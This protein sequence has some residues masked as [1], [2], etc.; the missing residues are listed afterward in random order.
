VSCCWPR[1]AAAVAAPAPRRRP[2]LP[3]QPGMAPSAQIPSPFPPP[4]LARLASQAARGVARRRRRP[5]AGGR[6]QPGR[7]G[8]GGRRLPC[9]DARQVRRGRQAALPVRGPLGGRQG[10]CQARWL[11]P[12]RFRCLEPAPADPR[13]SSTTPDGRLQVCGSGALL[14]RVCLRCSGGGSHAR[15]RC[16]CGRRPRGWAAR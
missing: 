4:L 9:R 5:R 12:A 10:R 8:G 15:V 6:L 7:A 14:G 3:P 1:A 2:P 13:P 11:E 16:G